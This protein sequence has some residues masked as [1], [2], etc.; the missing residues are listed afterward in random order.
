MLD[1]KEL[2]TKILVAIA[3]K[4]T[5]NHLVI[6]GIHICWGAETITLTEV[7]YKEVIVVLPYNYTTAPTCL[8]SCANRSARERT[9][10]ANSGGA[11]Y[12]RMLVGVYGSNA[13]APN[14]EYYVHW[15]TIGE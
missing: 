9:A 3:F 6:G 10:Y 12:N 14:N 13:T 7:G 15:L 8:A 5:G 1:I 11:P 4:Q 2:L